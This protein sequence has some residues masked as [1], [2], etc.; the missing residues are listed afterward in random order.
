[1]GGIGGISFEGIAASI[2]VTTFQWK[3]VWRHRE[4]FTKP[5]LSQGSLLGPQRLYLVGGDVWTTN[6]E[7][8]R[9][10]KISNFCQILYF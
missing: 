5:I 2:K 8:Q 7:L 4:R 6:F 1:M 10:N 9:F 3:K